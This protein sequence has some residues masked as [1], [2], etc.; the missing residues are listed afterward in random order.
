MQKNIAI[1]FLSY[2]GYAFVR[3]IGIIFVVYVRRLPSGDSPCIIFWE[4]NILQNHCHTGMQS[5]LQWYN[6]SFIMLGVFY[7]R[8]GYQFAGFLSH[9]PWR[10]A[11]KSCRVCSSNLH[12]WNK[13]IFEQIYQNT[14]MP[15]QISNIATKKNIKKLND[16]ET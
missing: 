14:L 11:E 3:N 13:K 9:S 6:R 8:N 16:T 5:T 2:L 1:L 12:G 10:S 15:F 4:Q 7:F